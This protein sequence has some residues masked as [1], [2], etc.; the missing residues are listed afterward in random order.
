MFAGR[1]AAMA[2]VAD[3]VSSGAAGAQD[4]G[5][6]AGSFC[7]ARKPATGGPD[8]LLGPA[9]WVRE[10]KGGLCGACRGRIGLHK[11]GMRWRQSSPGYVR[12]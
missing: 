1:I 3:V 8:V 7:G 10:A 9:A 2:A 12:R 5:V 6:S 11:E 4:Q